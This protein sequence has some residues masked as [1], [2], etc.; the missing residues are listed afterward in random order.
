MPVRFRQSTPVPWQRS[1]PNSVLV[2]PRQTRVGAQRDNDIKQNRD[3]GVT[4]TQR[5]PI[6][7]DHLVIAQR[8]ISFVQKQGWDIEGLSIER[9]DGRDNPLIGT[10]EGDA[11]KGKKLKWMLRLTVGPRDDEEF[12]VPKKDPLRL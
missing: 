2:D 7:N 9:Y 8:I 4:L 10:E 6:T 3:Y 12:K 1:K 5:L 11:W